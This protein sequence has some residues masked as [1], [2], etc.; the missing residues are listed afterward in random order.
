[1]AKCKYYNSFIE[2]QLRYNTWGG[3]YHEAVLCGR[4]QATKDTERC[5]CRGNEEK[6]EFY[7][8]IK[9][10]ALAANKAFK[11]RE[12]MELAPER[13]ANF[14]LGG[15]AIVTIKSGKTGKQFT[16]RVLRS[17]K[18][19]CMYSVYVRNFEDYGYQYVACYF[20]DTKKLK[21]TDPYRNYPIESCPP[22]IRAIKFL[23]EK[24]HNPPEQLIV[25][26]NGRCGRCGRPLTNEESMKTGFGAECY[27][28]GR[29]TNETN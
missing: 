5:Y 28:K 23:F 1:M 13:V 27:R 19:D 16:Y 29:K 20:S 25:Y 24:L 2:Q 3:T 11:E 9:E 8:D 12:L 6:C 17:K 7:P 14:V 10:R 26:H 22:H 4:C 21:L 18:D 15:K